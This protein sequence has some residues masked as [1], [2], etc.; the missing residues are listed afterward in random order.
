MK[1]T[2]HT[3]QDDRICSCGVFIAGMLKPIEQ[4]VDAVRALHVAHAHFWIKHQGLDKSD[5]RTIL[6]DPAGVSR[7]ID[8]IISC[9][10]C[11]IDVCRWRSPRLATRAL[12]QSLA[13]P[14]VIVPKL[15]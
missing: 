12:A 8:Q 1:N 13:A 3:L 14:G 5:S 15:R 7:V 10:E 9:K 4:S 11:G 6:V 2:Q